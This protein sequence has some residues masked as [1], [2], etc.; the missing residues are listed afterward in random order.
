MA[1]FTVNDLQ[2]GFGDTQVVNNISFEIEAGEVLALVGESGSGKSVSALSILSLL[3]E[4][5]WVK[6]DI[7]LEQKQLL[8]QPQQILQAL[9]GNQIGMVFQEPLTSLNPLHT[10]QKQINEVL[11]LHR[12]LNPA[13][14]RVRCVELLEL[15]GIENPQQ[16]LNSYPHELSGGQRQRVMIA[17][18]LANEPKLL[19]ADE[20]TTALDVTIQQQILNLLDELRRKLGMAILLIS[21]DL[22]IVRNYADR[23][24]VMQNGHIV[25]QGEVKHIFESPQEAYTQMLINAVPKPSN[26]PAVS[27]PTVLQALDLKVWFPLKTGFFKR[28][29]AY[30][31][32]VDGVSLELKRGETLGIVGESGSGK[33][34]LALAL[35]KLQRS[36]GNIVYHGENIE[37]LTQNQMRPLRKNLQIVFQDPFASLSPRMSVMEIISEGLQLHFNLT[38]AQVEQR[39]CEVLNEVG[40]DVQSR[41]RYP[42]EFSGGQRQRIAIARAIVLKPKIIVLDEPTSALDRS[43]QQQLLELLRD[44][45]LQHNLSFLFISHDLAV[46]RAL[47]HRVMVMKQGQVVEQGETEQVFRQPQQSYTR[48]LIEAAMLEQA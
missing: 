7:Y 19:I 10:V 5:S 4:G 23:V 22:N 2:I 44:L 8:N 21:H 36:K 33:S 18:A 20:P 38:A 34:T 11:F 46:I 1:L 17:M 48:A 27:G 25:E 24:A 41:F 28:T 26:L 32:A 15:V 39:V 12:G 14:A 47:A 3:G 16:R 35:L 42:H 43:V 40:L 13:Q 45:Q 9:R 31:K 6:G 37:S 29:S 30:I